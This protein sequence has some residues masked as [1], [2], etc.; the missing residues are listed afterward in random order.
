[1]DVE[2]ELTRR[3]AGLHVINTERRDHDW[4]F[5]FANNAGMSVDCPWRILARGR[6][7]LTSTDDGQM[8]GRSAPTEGAREAQRLLGQKAIQ[9]IA[10]RPDTGDLSVIFSDETTLEL[11]N[12]SAGYEGWQVNAAGFTV[13]AKG[14]GELAIHSDEPHA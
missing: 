12:M 6:I 13:I 5:G 11:L 1:M 7:A 8:F 3:L 10:V 9:R 14:G 4:A 2:T